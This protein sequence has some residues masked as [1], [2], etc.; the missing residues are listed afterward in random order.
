M[1]TLTINAEIGKIQAIINLLNAFD[2][3]FDFN[4]SEL[5]LDEQKKLKEAV[6]CT[7]NNPD[8]YISLDKMKKMNAKKFREYKLDNEKV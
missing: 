4:E 3:E 2:V 6:E 7:D 5:S 1:Y 8:K